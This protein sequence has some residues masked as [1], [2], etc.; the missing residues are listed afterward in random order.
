MNL[1]V[2]VQGVQNAC[3][4]MQAA[5]LRRRQGARRGVMKAGLLVQAES[6]KRTPVDTG[7]LWASADTIPIGTDER[8]I[9]RVLYGAS[10]ALFVHEDVTKHHPVGQD[11]FLSSAA[12][13]LKDDIR[14]IIKEEMSK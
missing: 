13:D 7:N 11:H 3:A 6:Q 8:P 1:T 5:I 10:Y 2:A 4:K 12:T 9:A 14:A